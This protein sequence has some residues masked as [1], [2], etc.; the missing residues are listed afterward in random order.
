MCVLKGQQRSLSAQAS[1]GKP[2]F[3]SLHVHIILRP[4]VASV[5]FG[6]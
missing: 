6:P 1:R 2:R 3:E 4:D 5:R